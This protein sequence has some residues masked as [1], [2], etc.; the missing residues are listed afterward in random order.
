MPWSASATAEYPFTPQDFASIAG[1]LRAD[2]GIA[3]TEGK[4]ALVYARLAKRLRALGL[5]DFRSYC[6]L[7]AGGDGAEER[8][9]M[10]T[11]LT[12]NLT[13]FLREP[14]HFEHFSATVLPRLLERARRGARVRIW[15]AACSTG[16]EPYGIAFALLASDP[17]A[18]A[19]DIRIL[20][21]DI[22]PKVLAAAQEGS[23]ADEAVSPLPP[24]W[25][26]RFLTAAGMP[27]QW[28]V[29]SAAR[30]LIAFR[31]L[32]LNAP[33]WPMR[34]RYDAIFCRNVAIYFDEGTQNR[35]WSRFAEVSGPG[36]WLY[37]GHS[38]R[39]GGPAAS[40]WR[41]AGLTTYQREPGA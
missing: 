13:R 24:A 17:N 11:A 21:T 2:A 12:T 28:R 22:D 26:T 37:I 9:E 40:R 1:M 41:S 5:R 25:R 36:G 27:G 10:L 8:R 23:Y 34:Q 38:E 19:H 32:N 30:D 18:A 3:L 15:S 6:A 39:V 31:E 16:E 4:A 14:H 35:L 29:A 33:S 20:A 7:V